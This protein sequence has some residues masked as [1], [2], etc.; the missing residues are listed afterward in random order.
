METLIVSEEEAG[1]R[2]DRW[3]RRRW[4][5][6]GQSQIEKLART[7]QIRMNGSRVRAD[8]RLAGG[9]TLRVPPLPPSPPPSPDG[10]SLSHQEAAFVRSLVLFEDAFVLVLAKPSGL[11]VQGGTGIGRSLD[12]LLSAFGEGPTR[13]RLV[14]R[15][16]RE[17]SGV[18]VLGRSASAAAFLAEAFRTRETRKIYWAITAGTPEPAR[19]LI[20]LA[21][22]KQFGREME[23][24]APA[25]PETAGT[26]SAVSRYVLLARQ[27]QA[28]W[29]ALEPLTGRTHQLRAHLLAIGHPIL[30]DRKYG[31]EAS[32]SL[33]RGLKLQLHARRLIL[34]HPQGGLID[35]SAPPGTEFARGMARFGFEAGSAPADPF[36]EEARPR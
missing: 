17:T 14:H 4:P 13:P 9:A 21:L 24:M 19:G 10:P 25:A 8:Q 28:G 7:G 11:A 23:R 5:H 26:R 20:S 32:R 18:I 3:L 30:G 35:V 15:L 33:G 27:D 1:L 2:L 16:D 22:A 34:P 12:A 36:G 31:D 6:L 29:L